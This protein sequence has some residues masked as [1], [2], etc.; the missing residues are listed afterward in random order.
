M[1]IQRIYDPANEL[2]NALNAVAD[3]QV[4]R[5]LMASFYADCLRCTSIHGAAT[6]DW[7][8]LNGAILARWPKGLKYIKELAWKELTA[9][10]ATTE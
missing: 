8:K 6:I 9:P 7:P 3:K 5:K 4:N 1:T 10:V 2:S